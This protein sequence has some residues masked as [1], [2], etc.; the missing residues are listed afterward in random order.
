MQIVE[1]YPALQGWE[2]KNLV[3]AVVN[4][5]VDELPFDAGMRETIQAG[6]ATTLPATIDFIIKASRGE[7]EIV[8]QIVDATGACVERFCNRC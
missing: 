8:N 1:Q 7:V 3:L 6:I 4:R 5:V 2:K